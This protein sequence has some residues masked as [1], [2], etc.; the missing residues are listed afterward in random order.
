MRQAEVVVGGKIDPLAVCGA[1]GDSVH[2]IQGAQLTPQPLRLQ[3]IQLR[4]DVP[5]FWGFLHASLLQ[6]AF[7]HVVF[8]HAKRERLLVVPAGQLDGRRAAL[9][10]HERH[11]E[12]SDAVIRFQ[13]NR[14][15]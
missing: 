1:H 8:Y 11:I 2:F 14:P 5:W 15:L 13:F 9:Q 12:V 7:H 6:A 4:G 3:L 10:E